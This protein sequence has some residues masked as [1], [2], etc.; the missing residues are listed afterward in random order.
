MCCIV[1]VPGCHLP[2]HQFSSSA[3]TG[4]G[5]NSHTTYGLQA[6]SLK[7]WVIYFTQDVQRVN[8]VWFLLFFF[9][10]LHKRTYLFARRNGG[11]GVGGS[12]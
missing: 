12:S 11:R 8:C 6:S 3:T 10:F 1:Y 5:E 2:T 9:F 7:T 4:M